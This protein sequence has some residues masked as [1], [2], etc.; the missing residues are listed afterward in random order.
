V[1]NKRLENDVSAN[2]PAGNRMILA[3]TAEII[4]TEIHLIH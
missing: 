1:E 4:P 2:R 3:I